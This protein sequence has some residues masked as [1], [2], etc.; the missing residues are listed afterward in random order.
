MWIWILATVG[1]VFLDQLTKWLAVAF[2]KGEASLPIISGVLQLTYLENPG[3]AFGMLKDHRWVFLLL[4][5]VAIIGV[6]VYMF[7][8]KPTSRLLCLSLAMIV[9][10]GIGNMIDRTILGYVVDFVDFCLIHFAIF[11]VADSFV[12]IGAGLFALYAIR[13]TIK[14]EK[15]RKAE[16]VAAEKQD[17]KPE[18]TA[19]HDGDH[20]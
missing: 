7:K 8:C 4:S 13:E 12:C 3:A 10:G 1:V 6:L 11:N 2:L 17:K 5:T 19:S 9:G 18:D 16:A 15:K 20:A 14:E